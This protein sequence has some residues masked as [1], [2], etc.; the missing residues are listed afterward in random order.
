MKKRKFWFCAQTYAYR[1]AILSAWFGVAGCSD[2]NVRPGTSENSPEKSPSASGKPHS[3]KV[4]VRENGGESKLLRVRPMDAPRDDVASTSGEAS[5]LSHDIPDGVRTLASSGDG[6][7]IIKDGVPISPAELDEASSYAPGTTL[8]RYALMSC[9]NGF[10]E[11]ASEVGRPSLRMMPLD[12]PPSAS[13]YRVGDLKFGSVGFFVTSVNNVVVGQGNSVNTGCSRGLAMQEALLCAADRLAQIADSTGTLRWDVKY[14]S[15]EVSPVEIEVTI[16]PQATKD[17]FIARDMALSTL[18]AMVAEEWGWADGKN[19][20]DQ[21]AEDLRT[22]TGDFGPVMPFVGIPDFEADRVGF[23]RESLSV[24]ANLYAA[25]AR[26]ARELVEDTVRDDLATAEQKRAAAADPVRGTA[27]MWGVPSATDVDAQYASVR[28]AIRTL[29]GRLEPLR[30]KPENLSWDPESGAYSYNPACFEAWIGPYD[31]AAKG[32]DYNYLTGVDAWEV[33]S[34]DVAAPTTGAASAL[35]LLEKLGIVIDLDVAMPPSVVEIKEGLEEAILARLAIDSGM[36]V[37]ALEDEVR[38][39]VAGLASE[40]LLWAVRSVYRKYRL[41][42]GGEDDT[43]LS[44][45][46]VLAS[47]DEEYSA[48]IAALGGIQLRGGLPRADLALEPLTTILRALEVEQCRITFGAWQFVDSEAE[49]RLALGG[50]AALQDPFL[51]GEN[52][53]RRLELLNRLSDEFGFS[54]LS[55][56]SELAAAEIRE[57]AAEAMLYGFGVPGLDGTII[58]EG[59]SPGD[60]GSPSEEHL[61]SRIALVRESESMGRYAECLAGTRRTCPES[62]SG[63]TITEPTVL[64]PQATMRPLTATIDGDKI[65]EITVPFDAPRGVAYTVVIRGS[66][67]TPGRVLGVLHIGLEGARIAAVS[68]LREK[69]LRRIFDP[70]ATLEPARSCRNSNAASLPTEYCIE[71]MNR[72]MFVPLA[73]ELTSRSPGIEDSWRHYLDLA[74]AAAAKADQLG[75]DLIEFGISREVRREGANES[76]AELCGV[77]PDSTS[78]GVG[79]SGRI[80]ETLQ[81]RAVNRCINEE[82]LDVVF[83]RRNPFSNAAQLKEA[84]CA[85]GSHDFCVKGAAEIKVAELGFDTRI[86]LQEVSETLEGSCGEILAAIDPRSSRT[87]SS[88]SLNRPR[89]DALLNRFWAQPEAMLAAL[90]RLTLREYDDGEWS[91]ALAGPRPIMGTD[92][93]TA[94]HAGRDVNDIFPACLAASGGCSGD[95]AEFIRKF[96]E[97]LP[98][99]GRADDLRRDVESAVF[100][101]A[102]MAGQMPAGTVMIP[103]PAIRLADPPAEDLI[104]LPALYGMGQFTASGSVF[105]YAGPFPEDIAVMGEWR[106][107]LPGYEASRVTAGSGPMVVPQWQNDLFSSEHDLLVRYALNAPLAFYHHYGTEEQPRAYLDQALRS[108]SRGFRGSCSEKHGQASWIAALLSESPAYGGASRDS[109]WL[110]AGLGE[111]SVCTSRENVSAGF[112][113]FLDWGPERN[114]SF[115]S[116]PSGEQLFVTNKVEALSTS[117]FDGDLDKIHFF[118]GRISDRFDGDPPFNG[119]RWKLWQSGDCSTG[120]NYADWANCL[121]APDNISDVRLNPASCS[122]EERVELFLYRDAQN[123]CE[124]MEALTRGLML[125]CVAAY[126]SATLGWGDLPPPIQSVEEMRLLETWSQRAAGA[127][128]EA[129]GAIALVNVPKR[130]VDA[131]TGGELLVSAAG[132]GNHGRL[133]LQLGD[134]LRDIE[135]GFS[136]I[137]AAYT[138]FQGEIQDARLSIE[139]A[140]LAEQQKLLEIARERLDLERM[141][142]FD[143]LRASRKEFDYSMQFLGGVVSNAVQGAS[144]GGPWGAVI[145]G[146][147]GGAMATDQIIL[148][149]QKAR[150]DSSFMAAWQENLAGRAGNAGSQAAVAKGFAVND[151]SMDTAAAFRSMDSALG[152]IR[153]SSSDALKVINSLNDNEAKARMALAKVGGVDFVVVGNQTV[154]LYVNTV[155]RRQFDVLRERYERALESAKRAA[156][157]ARLAIEQRLGARL[158]EVRH[159]IGPIDAPALWV[160]DLCSLSGIDYNSM[161]DAARNSV[162]LDEEGNLV[163]GA[164]E[165]DVIRG[166]ADQYIGDYV[167]K[168]REFMEFY[169]VEYPFHEA[170]DAALL[171]LREDLANTLDECYRS[172][173]NLLFYSDRLEAADPSGEGN[174]SFG[175][176]QISPCSESACL[177]VESG[178]TLVN[179]AEGQD[180][181]LLP[182]ENM[183]AHSW[184]YLVAPGENDQVVPG[185]PPLIYQSLR[186]KGGARY[187]L[188][189]WDMARM[190]DGGALAAGVSSGSEEPYQ[191]MVFDEQWNVIGFSVVQPSTGLESGANDGER[192]S[193]R[194][195]LVFT[196]PEDGVFHVGFTA[197]SGPG[198]PSTTLALA[199]VQVE[200]S[201][202]DF[203]SAYESNGAS[204]SK[205]SGSCPV[206]DPEMFRRRFQYRCNG[207]GCYYELK[208]PLIIDTEV[209]N[210]S[211]SGPNGTVARGNYNYRHRGLAVNVVGTGIVDCSK[212]EGSSC[213]GSGY[214]EYD[215]EHF[216]GNIPVLDYM[217]E[218]TCFDFGIG[219]VRSGKALA[220]ERYLTL[221]L[222]SADKGLVGESPI[223]KTELVGRPLSGTYRLRIKDHPALVWQNVEDVQLM[224]D[225]RYWSRVDRSY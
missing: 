87:D 111:R 177:R 80:D 51:L 86:T 101:L 74:E 116:L 193:S 187:V 220:A 178:V 217:N 102:A 35:A 28:H 34:R 42:V 26:L 121:A 161:R 131:V 194:R 73:N 168:L 79:P 162:T 58:I 109:V 134:H 76:F 199:N 17:R 43:S 106:V 138:M 153:Q 180:S 22:Q 144:V 152:S 62:L 203:A 165:V 105:H 2:E 71:G 66:G 97:E 115:Y 183:G 211:G 6:T 82:K 10:G 57:W 59:I 39:S 206:D 204:R 181:A 98:T 163:G 9:V 154:P 151:L 64:L 48:K 129:A 90:Q 8:M 139:S 216:A 137:A 176:W 157:L 142:A 84:F 49:R 53:R 192:W 208:D 149:E 95:R 96:F 14:E 222:G 119:G 75:R 11:G 143:A 127:V 198:V 4:L 182:P 32:T 36:E 21:H 100:H 225:Y 147:W 123:E 54:S 128:Q 7:T 85:Y 184:L 30:P 16:P 1:V 141:R 72:D 219:R 15:P 214:L 38:A 196:P 159:D 112:Y 92:A 20:V 41:L 45:L 205:V 37:G 169:N 212:V 46:D 44:G 122:P 99:P 29:T 83:L 170:D 125:S 200:R 202:N 88:L 23:N 166:F 186:L 224:L 12:A 215:L 175:R 174:A 188:S 3:L 213:Y 94:W 108:A 19:C 190:P 120:M 136:D 158:G 209:I 104:Q 118:S 191:A 189:W 33:R 135:S 93:G 69:L 167:A 126:D 27:R 171:S 47:T 221:P 207:E 24:R 148:Q 56:F 78:V 5:K 70:T 218:A 61:L 89:F 201:L 50:K 68:P 40:D 133:L 179:V 164:S 103:A 60:V 81:D 145:G 150:I 63:E 197:S 65:I 140:S 114:A 195:Q 124:A 155:H 210:S 18:G 117:I 113:S 110:R 160:D 172:S 31:P 77:F 132:E 185:D 13:D 130:V 25:A 173:K 156:Y 67:A 55:R 146:I 223:M 107:P 91:L 52:L